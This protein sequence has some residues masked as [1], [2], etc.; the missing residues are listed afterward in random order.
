[1]K[2]ARFYDIRNLKIEDIPIPEIDLDDDVIVKVKV[3]GICGSDISKYSKTGPHISGEVFGHE[4]SGD[5][6]KVGTNVKNVKPGDAVAVCPS[7]PCFKCDQ[8]KQGLFS[9]CENLGIIGNRNVGGCFAEYVKISSKNLIKLPKGIDYE[10][11]A[12]IEPSCIAG[13]GMYRANIKVGDTVAILGTGPIGLLLIQWAK[14][15]GATKV[16]AIDVFDEKLKIAKELGADICINGKEADSIEKVRQMTDLK[17]VDVAI[18]SAGTPLTSAQVLSL[19]RKGGTVLYAGVPYSDVNISRVHFEKILR[20]ELTVKGT[21][22]G[23]SY[24]FPGR[25][26]TSA[27]YYMKKGELKISPFVT[28][29]ITLDE[30]P[31]IFEKIHKRDIFFGKIM[32]N[33]NNN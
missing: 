31:E 23:N 9:R 6:I 17:G 19:P 20:N 12:G 21:W 30:L 22:F 4:F 13:H 7:L 5:V 29:R 32:V 1:M 15:F 8:C 27:I 33:I 26:W 25:E 2:A 18:E 28:H 10:T 11:A 24:P 3:A 14:I 16:I